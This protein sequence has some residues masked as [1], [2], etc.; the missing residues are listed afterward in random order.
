M[1]CFRRKHSRAQSTLDDTFAFAQN[2]II[3]K[4][5]IHQR[6]NCLKTAEQLQ[7]RRTV[8]YCTEVGWNS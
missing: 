6:Q 5:C 1:S 2:M 7:V 8:S 3:N 4:V